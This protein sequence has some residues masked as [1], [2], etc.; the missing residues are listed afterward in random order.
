LKVWRIQK[1]F[2]V[3]IVLSVC[4]LLM[5]GCEV[6]PTTPPAADGEPATYRMEVDLLGTR[7]EVLVDVQGKIKEKVEL[8]SADGEVSLSL[9]KGTV[10]TDEDGKP[11]EFIQ[12]ATDSSLPLPPEDAY[13][14]GEVYDLKPE[15]A[16]FNP[17]LMFTISYDPQELPEKVKESD[18]YIV[19]YDEATGWGRYSYKRVETDKHRV[20]TQIEY[21]TRHAILAP[22][23]P[24]PSK[25]TPAAPAQT[26][27]IVSLKE[28]LSNGK[29]TLAEFG[30]S[31]CIPCK[32]MKPIL[33]QLA[34]EY[35]EKLNV[36]IVE[37]YEQMEL[38]RSYKIMTIPTQVV[39]DSS[40]KEITRHI[41]LWPKE[42]IIA[43]LKKIGVD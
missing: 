25:A 27:R 17:Q 39:F 42:Q 11:L 7:H 4:I 15:G 1:Y 18:I 34:I 32:Q 38:T 29:P 23:P 41:G 3:W 35:E 12:V 37:V 33:E 36:A 28:A 24:A 9:K 31:T 20:S 21:L 6:T 13:I 26:S 8:S 2:P 30:A 22:M 10:V 14:I 5:A 40:G 16:T 43:Q 19:P